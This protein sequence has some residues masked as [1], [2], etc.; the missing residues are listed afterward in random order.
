MSGTA[1][2]RLDL[3]FSGIRSASEDGPSFR[4]RDWIPSY[5]D[6]RSSCKRARLSLPSCP[7]CDSRA[8]ATHASPLMYPQSRLCDSDI[9]S[10]IHQ[11]YHSSRRLRKISL[12][13][14]RQEGHL[15]MQF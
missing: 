15:R 13:E 10:R 11:S 6:C 7:S 5:Q 12:R 3:G 9:A 14:S 1:Q 2:D 4:E 8:S